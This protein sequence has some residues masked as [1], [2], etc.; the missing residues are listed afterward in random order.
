MRTHMSFDPRKTRTQMDSA[1]MEKKAKL[2]G[3][4]LAGV[5]FAFLAG[6]S[7][8]SGYEEPVEIDKKETRALINYARIFLLNS[9]IPLTEKDKQ[10]IKLAEPDVR[11]F[12]TGYKTGGVTIS[13]PVSQGRII[14]VKGKGNL[15]DKESCEWIISIIRMEKQHISQKTKAQGDN[16][17]QEIKDHHLKQQ[18]REAMEAAKKD[19]Q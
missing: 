11:A 13:W 3:I 17:I 2:A 16:F 14:N 12:S 1:G 8:R 10:V 18:I 15:V 4:V 9:S 19:K 7:C 5:I 6:M